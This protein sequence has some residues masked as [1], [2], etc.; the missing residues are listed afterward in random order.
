MIEAPMRCCEGAIERSGRRYEHEI[1]TRTGLGAFLVCQPIC[2]PTLWA[3]PRRPLARAYSYRQT[4]AHNKLTSHRLDLP[5]CVPEHF[6]I[7]RLVQLGM[8][9]AGAGVI[10]EREARLISLDP[11]NRLPRL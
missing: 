5:A 4:V 10:A 11:T 7:L 6:D 8:E 2:C 3:E 1:K 9:G